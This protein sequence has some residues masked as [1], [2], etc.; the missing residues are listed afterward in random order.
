M[1]R[2]KMK[3]VED[4]RRSSSVFFQTIGCVKG[5]NDTLVITITD[6]K[7]QEVSSRE[8]ILKFCFVS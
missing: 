2:W 4:G 5:C 3:Q 7:S 6:V 1:I 8:T